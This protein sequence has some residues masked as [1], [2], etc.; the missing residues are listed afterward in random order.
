VAV[1]AEVEPESAARVHRLGDANPA[2]GGG[3]AVGDRVRGGDGG[4]VLEADGDR[5]G[6]E[7]N[8]DDREASGVA[9]Q[10]RQEEAGDSV[11]RRAQD[12]AAAD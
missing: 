7:E 6:A 4:D 1:L 9:A 12:R 11:A 8:R 3:D 10:H 2:G 5:V